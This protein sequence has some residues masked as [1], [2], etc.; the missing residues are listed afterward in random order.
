MKS[1]V[2][3]LV[4]EADHETADPMAGQESTHDLL[5]QAISS[6]LFAITGKQYKPG[7]FIV[8]G[9]ITEVEY[10]VDASIYEIVGIYDNGNSS[11]IPSVNFTRGEG[12]GS[13]LG[14]AWMQFPSGYITFSGELTTEGATVYYS[15]AFECPELDADELESPTFTDTAVAFYAAAYIMTTKGAGSSD[16]SQ[17]RQKVDAGNP[18]DLPHLK[19][20]NG[21]LKM[22][23]DAFNRLPTLKRGSV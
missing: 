14:N 22:F 1:R 21:Y 17:F 23:S 11:F 12:I 4:A 9:G 20:A 5:V 8:D 16:I 19:M 13:T 2:L 7:T 6:G 10:P 3:R 15:Q 18:E